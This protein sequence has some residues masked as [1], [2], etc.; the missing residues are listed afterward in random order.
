LFAP[1][2]AKHGSLSTW[3]AY[4]HHSRTESSTHEHHGEFLEEF[5]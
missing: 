3:E 1:D 4:P 2:N 5:M